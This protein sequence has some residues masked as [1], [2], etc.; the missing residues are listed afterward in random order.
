MI[1]VSLAIEHKDFDR[2][3]RR[4]GH[5]WLFK[6][7]YPKQPLSQAPPA[8]TK[9]PPHWRKFLKEFHATYHGIC[10][11]LGTHINLATGA[12][13]VDHLAPKSK[14]AGLAYEWSN[15]R[16]ASLAMN[17]RK[18]DFSDVL[19]PCEIPL[20]LS[21]FHLILT[22]GEIKVNAN[23]QDPV[24]VRCASHTIDRL[25]LDDPLFREDR[26]TLYVEYKDGSR[27]AQLMQRYHPFVWSEIVR[28]GKQ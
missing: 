14:V 4:P 3:V 24:L 17:A 1:H 5:K 15:F 6:N 25:K 16:L 2:L 19:D 27:P 22:T 20:G 13:S 12:A 9:F 10:A 28:Q 11:Y 26:A 7:L 18:R 21:V 8:K 23:L